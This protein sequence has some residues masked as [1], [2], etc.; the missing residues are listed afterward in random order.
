MNNVSLSSEEF[1]AIALHKIGCNDKL[2]ADVYVKIGEKYIKFKERGDVISEEKFNYFIS[3]NVK[4][5]YVHIDALKAFET[6]LVEAK[7]EAIESLISEIGEENRDLAQKQ[8]DL[9]ETIYEVF[10]NEELSNDMVDILK[11]QVEDFILTVKNK[12]P[13]ADIFL[14]LASMNNTVAEHSMNVAN[15]S[16]LFGMVSGQG[17]AIVLEN[18]Y[19]G[20]LFHD[21]GKAKIP[22]D[23]LEKPSSMTYEKAIKNHPNAAVDFLKTLPN[24]PLAVITIVAEHHEQFSG[25][26]YPR[27]ISGEAIYGLSRIVQIANVFDNIVSENR[28]NKARM[29]TNAIKVLEYDRGKQFDPELLPRIIDCLK[30]SVGSN[31]RA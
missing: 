28:N 20:A 7:K 1:A 21:Y 26:G 3:K 8:I 15:L 13:S 17:N 19:M 31:S 25:V 12:N 10:F 22:A 29:Y 16:L 30:Y 24:I 18:L 9:R 27:G 5:L 4:E 23:I 6:A 11:R 2:V 14:K